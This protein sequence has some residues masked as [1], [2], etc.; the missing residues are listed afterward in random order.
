MYHIFC[1][2]SSVEEHLGSFQLLAIINK[3]AINIVEHVSL[4]Y[5][6]TS[7]RYM[8][9]SGIV[10]SS[11]RTI[12]SFLRKCQIDFQS[13]FTSLQSY[14]QWRSVPLSPYP[15]QHLLLPEFLILDILKCSCPKE[16][17]RQKMKQRLKERPSRD[18]PT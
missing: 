8:P 4:L 5:F 16:R 12:N 7:F 9:S 14:Q 15:H 18:C 11:G 17:Q 13:D 2:H 10:G 1:I 6:G 3:A